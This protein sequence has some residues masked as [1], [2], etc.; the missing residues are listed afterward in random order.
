MDLDLTHP[1]IWDLR[2][3]AKRRIP[4]FAFEYLDSATGRETGAL[5][6]RAA[7]D[8]V[9]FMPSILRG[10]IEP[11]LSTTI[12]GQT[13]DLPVGIAPVGMSG[14]IW[15]NAEAILAE[16]A[17]RHNIPFSQS[18]VATKTPEDTGGLTGGKGWFQHY[19]VADADI[20]R[21]M[22]RRIK[23]SGW[24][25]LV[26]TVD[27]P[28]ESRRERQRKAQISVP[29]KLTPRILWSIAMSPLWAMGT[30]KHGSPRLAFP[31][32]Y[33]PKS[34]G[35]DGFVHAGRLIRGAPD[36]DYIKACRDDWDGPLVIKGVMEP[37]D[38]ERLVKL[39]ADGIWVSNHSARQLEAAPAALTQLPLVR[40]A[41]GPNVPL[42]FDSGVMGGLDALR[43]LAKGA[44]FVALGRAFHY[45]VAAF[46]A[47]GVDHLIHILR[48][49][50]IAN[51]E[52]IGVT[53]LEEL[54]ERLAT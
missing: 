34:S 30:L 22:L 36:W 25:A 45:A 47:K 43:A 17:H 38:A 12:F 1:S 18:T 39:G 6:N 48:A 54:A 16:A 29:P 26:V 41:V 2:A 37:G 23:D 46:G 40:E 42:I 35:S 20:R 28:G 10:K 49:D 11:E 32:S 24:H 14:L 4:H 13:Y 19:P 5:R 33:S 15:P 53:R 9:E 50:M 8:A 51:L 21:D 31:E 7:L 27:V 3:T 52:Q 44:N